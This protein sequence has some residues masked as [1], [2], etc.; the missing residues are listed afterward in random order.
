LLVGAGPGRIV[1]G[2]GRDEPARL[3]LAHLVAAEEMLLTR[4]VRA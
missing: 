2:A 3:R 1:E 4:Y